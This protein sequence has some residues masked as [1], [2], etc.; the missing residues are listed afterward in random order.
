MSNLIRYW[1][2][3]LVTVGLSWIASDPSYSQAQ[4]APAVVVSAGHSGSINQVILSP[5]G[6][7][8]ASAG[9]DKTIKIWDIAT[10]R[11]LRTLV[12]HDD[13][14]TSI[15]LMPD[16]KRI[17]S[18]SK[19][20]DDPVRIW[21]SETGEVLKK[22]ALRNL[23]KPSHLAVTPDGVLLGAN[24]HSITRRDAETGKLLSRATLEIFEGNSA[25]AV[26]PDYSL[27]AIGHHA[28]DG[29]A[30]SFEPKGAD[31][32]IWNAKTGKLEKLLRPRH[33]L[34]V[35]AVAFSPDGRRLASASWDKT[36]RIWDVQTGELLQTLTGHTDWIAA[37]KF[38]PDGR[39]IVSTSSIRKD[40]TVRIWDAS[41]GR[42]LRTLDQEPGEALEFTA[43]GRTLAVAGSSIRLLDPETGVLRQS[44]RGGMDGEES[45][46]NA[47]VTVLPAP[48][49]KWFS[50]VGANIAVLDPDSGSIRQ[51]HKSSSGTTERSIGRDSRG[52]FVIPIRSGR[53]V[54]LWDAAGGQLVSSINVSNSA[55]DRAHLAT[56]SPDGQWLATSPQLV[57]KD[58]RKY[59]GGGAVQIW[60][61][62]SGRLVRTL[63]KPDEKAAVL[64]LAFSADSRRFA[65]GASDGS[66]GK[67]DTIK[68]FDVGSWRLAKSMGRTDAWRIRF[69]IDGRM[70]FVSTGGDQNVAAFDI[71]TGRQTWTW[72]PRVGLVHDAVPGPDNQW[73]A[74]T[75]NPDVAILNNKTGA[76]IRRLEKNPGDSISLGVSNDGL[77]VIA[78][79]G[80]RTSAIW[81]TQSGALLA[82]TVYGSHGSTEWVTITPEGFFISSERGAELLH[83]VQGMQLTG[84][85]QV[86]Q[87]LY[88]PDLVREK[89]AG[90]PRGLVREAAAK[91]DLAKVLASGAPPRVAIT[92]PSSALAVTTEHASVS[93]DINE[94]GG[95]IGRIEWRVNG[96]TVGI[97]NRDVTGAPLRLTRELPLDDGENEVEVV[98]Y[99]SANL[100]ASVSAR[101]RIDARPEAARAAARLFVL[102]V[103]LNDYADQQLKLTYALPDAKALAQALTEAGKGI[104]Q[105][106]DVTLVQDAD[107][108]RDKLDAVFSELAAKVQP[109]DTFVFFIGGH[110]KTV[111]GRYYFI[112]QQFNMD[113]VRAA[114]TSGMTP[115]QRRRMLASLLHKEVVAQ[116]IPQEQWQA[117]F[118]KIPARKSVLLFDTC[119]SG[120]LTDEGRETQTLERGAASDR[121]AQAT[122][123]TILTAASGDTDANEGYRGHGLFTYHV[124]EALQR[125]D[126]DGNGTIELAELATYV[127]S[128]VTAVSEQV[129]KERQVPQVRLTSNYA[130]AKPVRV[131]PESGPGITIPVKP[132]HRIDAAA[133]LVVLP[134]VGA[135]RVRKLEPKTPVTTVK[136]EAGWTLVARE[137]TPLGY[138]ATHEL[139]PIQ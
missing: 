16:G 86:Y 23:A 39:R 77:K 85:E 54:T 18:A 88:R 43:D 48:E 59:W 49:N 115:A 108:R 121:L 53:T 25:F 27:I 19:N 89:L 97:E 99:N 79:N 120:T 127:Y 28:E 132:T 128:H 96:V 69:S 126:G 4:Q 135:R 125:A 60:N 17:I 45:P 8:L 52:R 50:R 12:G 14:V 31:V 67:S 81:S 70:I 11:L 55:A 83:V 103:G 2:M 34:N 37:V 129:F 106:V 72:G 63:S 66:D 131:L 101:V 100:V 6:R 7:W 98:A 74:L 104:Y 130:I 38:S 47:T 1:L 65:F 111:D 119:E 109:T 57:L 134:A 51:I 22:W 87:S 114:Q 113:S 35:S 133:D 94:A 10:G 26:S 76:L 15:A 33:K 122:G 110:G 64:S 32:T 92:N 75:A 117:W 68:I 30:P 102:A 78:G 73:I 95:G 123:R 93:A 21:S 29:L 56:I 3:I 44:M 116:G 13:S 80:N 90:D 46:E 36:I 62:A 20:E 118:A 42:L 61:I 40:T 138:V 107:V 84:I 136:S 105:N 112:P 137:G 71:A 5:D 91:L 139:M 24:V 124:L 58:G 41:T 82:T 9:D